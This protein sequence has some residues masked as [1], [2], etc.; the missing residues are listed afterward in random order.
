MLDTLR[1][2]L[3]G[4]DLER[5]RAEEARLFTRE[6]ERREELPRRLASAYSSDA[7]N[8]VELGTMVH[9][10]QP[11]RVPP[12]RLAG[13]WSV[14]GPSG[15]GKSFF[16]VLIFLAWLSAGL[17]RFFLADPKN[18]T[19]D[20]VL[21]AALDF[22]KRLPDKEAV[23]FLQRIAIVDVFSKQVLPQLNVLAAEPGLDPEHQSFELGRLLRATGSN[24]EGQGVRQDG[25]WYPAL[26]AMLRG[27]LPLPAGPMVLRHP[28][29]LESL[30]ERG[31]AP[32]FMRMTAARLREEASPDRILGVV[33]R[34]ESVLRGRSA[35]LALSAP[36]CIDF[37]RVLENYLFLMPL[38]PEHGSDDDAQ[39][40]RGLTWQKLSRSIRRRAN[41]APPALLTLDEFPLFLSL[42]GVRVADDC[43]TLLRVSRSKGISLAL[44]SQDMVSIGKVSASLPAVMKHNCPWHAI[45]RTSDNWDS[46]LPVSGFRPKPPSSLWEKQAGGYMDR[47]SERQTLQAELARLPNRALYLLDQR[48]GLPALLMRTKD[49]KFSVTDAEVA[50]FKEQAMRNDLVQPV[51]ELE[52]AE[53]DL[54]ERLDA[55][56]GRATTRPKGGSAGSTT[57]KRGGSR[58]L[59]GIG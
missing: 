15:A 45:F 35:R 9:S 1:H 19:I 31:I 29:I 40:F 42:S 3:N 48:L 43:E 38:C 54:A 8:A 34:L 11:V 32:E 21:R 10:G 36:K 4:S 12:E 37:D 53:R 27:G 55:L 7:P 6:Q 28:V 49:V 18:E 14:T 17:R 23:S 50:V 51:V 26:E 5:A 59:E 20:L 25:I 13:S 41:G 33:S 52:R 58:P 47:G 56:R 30:A 22:A 16:L 24:L 2:L 46:V 39:F 57:T 44:L